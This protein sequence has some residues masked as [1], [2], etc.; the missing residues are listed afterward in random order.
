MPQPYQRQT[1][2][3]PGSYRSNKGQVY[4]QLANKLQ[5]FS[6][7]L[8]QRLDVR[9]Q[10]EGKAAG[11][12]IGGEVEAVSMPDGSTI[13]GA[14]F[15]EGA[16][17]AHLASVKMDITENLVRIEGSSGGDPDAFLNL[18]AGYSQGLLEGTSPEVRPLAE[19]EIGFAALKIQQKLR[20]SKAQRDRDE[21]SELVEAGLSD[22]EVEALNHAEAGDEAGVE[23]T[24][25]Q[26]QD[27]MLRGEDAGLFPA[28]ETIKRSAKLQK[29]LLR[30]VYMGSFQRELEAG[31]GVEFME[32]F[33][34]NKDFSPAERE[35]IASKM[36]TRMNSRHKVVEAQDK[37]E[38]GERKQRY[39]TTER[40]VTLS[41]L[42]GTLTTEDLTKL[43]SDDDIEPGLARTMEK[44]ASAQGVMHDDDAVKLDYSIN[45]L[46]IP[47]KD[48]AEDDRLTRDTRIAL[49]Q[50]RRKLEAD[51][52]NWRRTQ[53][54]QE[55]T[56]RI[57]A[58]F[59]MVDGLIAQ[60]D[61]EKAKRAGRALTTLFEQV[62]A[63]PLESRAV[64]S[65]E[66]ANQII[67]DLKKGD[68]VEELGFVTE[69]IGKMQYQTTED[70][71]LAIDS[72]DVGGHEAKVIRKKLDRLLADKLRLE[73]EAK[74]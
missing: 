39:E 62:E 49:I 6:E 17:L 13:R 66:I 22:I 74:R 7:R 69:S 3:Q 67:A 56:R 73:A 29:A 9:A 2:Y 52:G 8:Q 59:G 37:L 26:Y 57:K 20:A 43:L 30:N 51:A 55:S 24:L 34:K 50:E 45:L 19:Q 21:Q 12:A 54:G 23:K 28:G 16:N 48:I 58:E 38:E 46:Q 18:V 11:R 70:L 44:I 27:V 32:S 60:M 40:E 72:G 53:N 14:A 4:Q 15:R 33:H 63:L 61:P 42:E 35:E 64:Q 10:A 47:E 41:A 5:G 36:I 68:S 71:D 31:R 25:A 1:L 65:V